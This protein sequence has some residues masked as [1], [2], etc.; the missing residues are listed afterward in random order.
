[1]GII[2]RPNI[3]NGFNPASY[4]HLC[5]WPVFYQLAL[6]LEVTNGRMTQRPQLEGLLMTRQVVFCI[7]LRCLCGNEV[8]LGL[9]NF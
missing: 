7:R 8:T 9:E 6:L 4:P 3:Y 1:M 5:L 2:A